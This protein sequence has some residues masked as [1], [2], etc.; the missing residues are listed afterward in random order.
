MVEV[1]VESDRDQ[2]E[3]AYANADPGLRADTIV[4]AVATDGSDEFLYFGDAPTCES[5]AVPAAVAPLALRAYPNPFNPSTTFAFELERA[6]PVSLRIHDARGRVVR[7]LEAGRPFDSGEHRLR[8]RGVDDHGA[9][10]GS[11][12]YLLRLE[13]GAQ[14]AFRRVVLVE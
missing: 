10:V 5:T 11:G 14:S 3:A 9:R 7:T 8:W 4:W 1:P 6:A 13:A 12:V 2:V